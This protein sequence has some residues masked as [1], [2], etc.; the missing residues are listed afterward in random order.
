M[1][2][3]LVTDDLPSKHI[4]WTGSQIHCI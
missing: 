4:H 2:S 1:S 3:S